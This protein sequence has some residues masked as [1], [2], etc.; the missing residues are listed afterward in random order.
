MKEQNESERGEKM[1]E[2]EAQL[3]GHQSE[4]AKLQAGKKAEQDKLKQHQK[5]VESKK[6]EIE[7]K[8]KLIQ[9][10]SEDR[11]QLAESHEANQLNGK[12]RRDRLRQFTCRDPINRVGTLLFLQTWRHSCCKSSCCTNPNACVATLA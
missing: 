7:K 12:N 1:K 10:K 11:D 8:T 4:F 9:K 6:K 5:Q 2:L 3:S